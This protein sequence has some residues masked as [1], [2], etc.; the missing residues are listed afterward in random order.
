[1]TRDA[2]KTCVG[3]WKISPRDFWDMT[4]VEY[5][6]LHASYMEQHQRQSGALTKEDLAELDEYFEANKVKYGRKR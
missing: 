1:M 6:W 3:L 2:Y 5:W 4:L